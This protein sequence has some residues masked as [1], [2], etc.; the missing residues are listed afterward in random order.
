MLAADMQKGT[1]KTIVIGSENFPEE[2][3]LANLYGHAL[4]DAGF[5]VVLRTNLGARQVVIPALAHASLDLVPE[6]AGAL[7]LYLDPAIGTKANSL[8]TVIPVLRR[9]LAK[10]GATVL[11]AAPAVDTNVFAV[12]QSTKRKYHLTTLSSLKPYAS[13]LTLGG[14]PE[15]PQNAT[16]ELGLER[17]Y[18][19]HFKAFVSTDEAGPISV[20]ALKSGRAQVAEF[21]SSN[22]AIQ[23]NHFYELRDNRHMQAADDVIPVIRKA[24]NSARIAS[25]LNALSKKLSTDALARMNTAVAKHESPAS[26][27]AR[28]LAS[29]GLG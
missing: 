17:V 10:H 29:E 23:D 8:S 24:V 4:Q 19:L 21:F 5:N 18:G 7:A 22:G 12:T 11:Q 25:T 15:C 3:L 26:V 28:W 16:C 13:R 20:A 14:P 6:Y 27:A 9:L 1:S 2:V